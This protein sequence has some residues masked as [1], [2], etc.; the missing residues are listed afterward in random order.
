MIQRVYLAQ[1]EIIFVYS[2]NLMVFITPTG[3]DYSAVELNL[4]I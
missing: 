3:C 2:I 1:T 4:E